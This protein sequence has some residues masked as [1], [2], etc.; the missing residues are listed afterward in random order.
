MYED[1]IKRLRD[2]HGGSEGIKMCTEAA[3]AIEILERKYKFQFETS[4]CWYDKCNLLV[5]ELEAVKRERDAAIK[6]GR[7]KRFEE[8]GGNI[9]V[10]CSACRWK[11]YQHG[12]YKSNLY[13]YCPNCGAKMDAE[14]E[15]E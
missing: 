1:L 11:D 14:E 8:I 13:N 10:S 12:K 15:K 6:H 4:K 5:N 2:A 7:W 3:D 9:G